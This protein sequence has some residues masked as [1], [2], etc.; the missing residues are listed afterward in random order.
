M[1]DFDSTKLSK[2]CTQCG[3]E[4][5][6][7]HFRLKKPNTDRFDVLCK[8]CKG[9]DAMEV[10]RPNIPEFDELEQLYAEIAQHPEAIQSLKKRI[11]ELPKRMAKSLSC[12]QERIDTAFILYWGHPEMSVKAIAKEL[13]GKTE[14]ELRKVIV[15]RIDALACRYCGSPSLLESRADE[16]LKRDKYSSDGIMC[17]EC[18][19]IGHR[20]LNQRFDDIKNTR[21][22]REEELKTMP[23]HE[24]LK[25]PE[26]N[27]L[28]KEKLQQAGFRCQ[29]CNVYGQPLQVHHRTYERR[30]HECSTDLIVLCASCHETFHRNRR[31]VD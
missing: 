23:Y 19:M 24:Y 1:T 22:P 21:R 8:Q 4:K 10:N 29:L 30:G 27:R 2:A 16:G 7:T 12:E 28:R 13:L 11:N 6:I 17:Y 5:P 25:T 26:W 9:R 15:W 14:K 31:S 18:F 20:G 3:V